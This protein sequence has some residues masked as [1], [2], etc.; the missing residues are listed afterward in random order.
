MPRHLG[1]NPA[2]LLY[3]R[4]HHLGSQSGGKLPVFA[5]FKQYPDDKIWITAWS[6]S[7]EPCIVLET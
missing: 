1:R 5:T 7:N 4:L 3:V 6:Y 2:L